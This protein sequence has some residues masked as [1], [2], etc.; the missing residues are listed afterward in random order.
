MACESYSHQDD[1]DASPCDT[2]DKHCTDSVAKY[3][4][5]AHP[6]RATFAQ[7]DEPVATYRYVPARSIYRHGAPVQPPECGASGQ[8]H[9]HDRQY[10]SPHCSVE[11]SCEH[12]IRNAGRLASPQSSQE[13]VVHTTCHT[14]G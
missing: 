11:L 4:G 14:T 1:C 12:G 13:N 6:Y 8:W 7:N 9:V 2:R 3:G 10:S 5:L